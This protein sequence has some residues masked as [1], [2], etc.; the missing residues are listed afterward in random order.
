VALM[1]VAE[2]VRSMAWLIVASAVIGVA[3]GLGYRF[4]LE[5]VNEMAPDD[6]RSEVV[7]GYLIVCYAAISLPVIGLGLVTAA[8]TALVADTIFGLLVAALAIAA[9]V[10]ELLLRARRSAE[11][12]ARA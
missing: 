6:R 1:V 9:L 8:S 3:S 4:G 5:M 11:T 2:H 7:S 12:H 10:I